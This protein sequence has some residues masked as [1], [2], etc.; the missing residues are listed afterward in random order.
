M[1][2]AAA[3][4]AMSH[5][6]IQWVYD[7]PVALMEDR[8]M[9]MSETV[10]Q[11]MERQR[12]PYDLVTHPRSAS[13]MRTASAA[14]I[15]PHRLAK[16]VVLEDEEGQVMAVLPADRWLQLGRVRKALGRNLGLCTERELAASFTD[17]EVG[18]VPPIGD[19]YGMQTIV[20]EELEREPEVF[21][22]A[23]DHEVLM[24]LSHD[25]FSRLMQ[26]VCHDHIARPMR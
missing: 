16:A 13:S 15:P 12:L 19:A 20:D 3:W 18:A 4:S 26:N 17:C 5:G 10:R 9:A 1:L 14:R 21:L 11:Y 6:S 25:S 2:V 8:S 23:G 7:D 24:R 22:E